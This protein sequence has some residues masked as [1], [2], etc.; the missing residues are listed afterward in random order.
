MRSTEKERLRM[1]PEGKAIFEDIE[2]RLEV[3]ERD[4]DGKGPK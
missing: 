1:G 4:V 3:P 2:G